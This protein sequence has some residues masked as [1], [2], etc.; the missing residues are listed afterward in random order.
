MCLVTKFVL[1]Q[2]NF[3]VVELFQEFVSFCGELIEYE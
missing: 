2:L 1:F 3:K